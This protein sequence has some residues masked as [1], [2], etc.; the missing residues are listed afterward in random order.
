[1]TMPGRV[2]SK[3]EQVYD[4]VKEAI[5]SGELEPGEAIDK[6]ALCE[7]L[8]VSRFPVSAAIS[9]L[10]FERLVRVEPQ[11]GSFVAS[12]SAGDVREH[13][14]VRRALE[15][16]IAAEAANRLD[17]TARADLAANLAEAEEAAR[18]GDRASF[19]IFDVGFHA[20]LTQHLGLSRSE[21]I[22]DGVRQQL[23]RPRRLLMTPPGRM[24][25][26]LAEHRTIFAAIEARD[27]D[28]ARAAMTAHIAAVSRTFEALAREKPELFAP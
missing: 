6:L 13:L 12:I 14:F 5:L 21:D 3:A 4:A 26:T 25:L 8:G 17:E 16:E 27:P 18:E 20:L 24:Q 23:E 11:H 9:R 28:A 2:N 10:A 22:L 19:Y 1:M 15:G 7:K